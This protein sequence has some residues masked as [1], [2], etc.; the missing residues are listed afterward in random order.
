VRAEHAR[1]P[2]LS[3]RGGQ[4]AARHCIGQ[5]EI[6]SLSDGAAPRRHRP[7]QP[8]RLRLRAR[9]IFF[10]CHQRQG[11]LG[12][13][14]FV[15]LISRARPTLSAG[16]SNTQLTVPIGVH[17]GS[18]ATCSHTEESSDRSLSSE[19]SFNPSKRSPP[20]KS[21][22]LCEFALALSSRTRS[23]RSVS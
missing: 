6:L 5:P 17:Q 3:A 18:C 21:V 19:G 15:L 2:S 7:R 1:W 10:G 4:A 14:S 11:S 20:L 8:L 23:D 12:S 13:R 16:A 9:S 22:S